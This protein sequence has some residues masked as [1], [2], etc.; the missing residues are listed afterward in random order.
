MQAENPK[1]AQ[2]ADQR[3]V[4]YLQDAFN[5]VM[6][7][8]APEQKY[9]AFYP[10]IIV[11]ITS[12][13][14]V[15]NRLSFG[16]FPEPGIY[17]TTVTRPQL[18]ADY[19]CQQL[20]EIIRNHKVSIL[21]GY[22]Q[23]PIPIQFALN[24][25]K[26]TKPPQKTLETHFRDI[27]DTPDLST[28]DDR[29][30]NS[31]TTDGPYSPLSLFTAQRVDYSLARIEHYTAT[32]PDHFQNHV[33]FTNYQFYVDE[34]I[35]YAK[36]QIADP[37]SGY[38]ELVMPGNQIFSARGEDG[39]AAQRLPQMPTR[40]TSPCFDLMLGLWLVI[41]QGCATASHWEISF[42]HTLTCV[43]TMCLM[44][45]CRLGCPSRRLR[46]FRSRWKQRWLRSLI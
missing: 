22:S 14:P 39:T 19:L 32:A 17:G 1:L 3:A 12:Y 42:W 8:T 23:T 45:T 24:T 41:A 11:E 37:A 5:A 10:E 34:F 9:R 43:R 20:D 27:F 28:I 16:H 6:N 25:K 38:S 40:I 46:K 18:F 29:I 21:I 26:E 31:E 13:T 33:L 36:E 35:G 30:I 2:P 15:D 44:T 4:V 7:D